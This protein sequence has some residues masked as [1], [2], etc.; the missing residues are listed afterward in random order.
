MASYVISP[1]GG[2]IKRFRGYVGKWIPRYFASVSNKHLI[3]I[4]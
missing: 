2:D 4:Y 3:S 1:E